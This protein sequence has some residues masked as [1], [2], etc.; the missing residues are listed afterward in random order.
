MMK[1]RY[2]LFIS[3]IVLIKYLSI[4]GKTFFVDDYGAHSDDS[5]DDSNAIQLAVN[6]AISDGT[7]NDIVFGYGIYTISSTIE[8]D[9]ATNLTITGQGIDQTFL[10]GSNQIGIFLAHYGQGLIFKS[11][12][13]D[14]DPLPFTAGYVVNVDDKYLDVEIVPPHQPDVGRQV[15]AILRY[16]PIQMRPAFGP[17]TYEIY[18]RLSTN[19]TTTLISPGV[20]RIPLS[21]STR[22]AKGDPIVARYVFKDPVIYIKDVTDTIIQSINTY[23]S[24]EMGIV[25]LRAT[26]LTIANY[27]ILP[28][29]GRWLSTNVDCIHLVDTREYISI[30]DSVCQ[31]MGDDGLNVH[32]TFFLVTEIINSTSAVIEATNGSTILDVGVGTTLEFSSKQQPFS[33]YGNGTVASII[34]NSTK[35]RNI[36]FINPVP[37]SVGDWICVADTP[38]LTIRNYTVSHNRARG[39]LLETRNIDI[40]QSVFNRTS[41][42]AV[43]IQPSMYWHEGPEARN[44]TLVENLYMHNNEGI[45]QQKAIISILPDPVQLN[46]II[47]DIRIESSSFYF[48]EY[49]QG[50]LQSDNANN[51]FINGNYISTN[52]LTSF[53]SICNS[54]NISAVNNCV[55]TNH[56]KVD[57]YYIYDDMNPCSRNMSSRIHLPPSAFN[58]TFPPP[59]VFRTDRSFQVQKRKTSNNVF[60][61]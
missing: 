54:R 6:E 35:S 18:Q 17:N 33:V 56:T 39:V 53:I 8:I 3:T 42:P 37:L 43:L 4:E 60:N 7:V 10:V 15:Q 61:S 11:F 14:Y 49:T 32:A 22:F 55:V 2:G 30:S 20:L 21:R 59:V 31:G 44:I 36:T 29:A 38:Q 47:N 57:Q 48:G 13:I 58:S 27:H 12:S 1:L 25:S 40:R 46:P 26:R 28:R 9:N 50:F 41:G 19:V 24:W 23:S 51:V 34:F 5:I 45:A 16:D 52:N